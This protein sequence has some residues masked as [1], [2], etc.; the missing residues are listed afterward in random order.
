MT[1]GW[2]DYARHVLA[3]G[4]YVKKRLGRVICVDVE[5]VEVKHYT[6]GLCETYLAWPG[7][8]YAIG[9]NVM[10]VVPPDDVAVAIPIDELRRHPIRVALGD[11][12]GYE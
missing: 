11:G 10:C 4:L 9:D 7:C 5:T 6:T 3:I 12:Q 2:E 8:T 1:I